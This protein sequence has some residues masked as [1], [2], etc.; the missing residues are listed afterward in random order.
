MGL[1][2]SPISEMF[3]DECRLSKE[4]LLGKEGQGS[5]I[6]NETMAWERTC[7]FACHI[8]AIERTLEE[9][10]KYAKA[11][12][13]FGHPIGKYQ[14]IAHKIADIKVNL[15]LG[16]LILY[17]AG[18]MKSKNMN[19]MLESAIA[20]L[21]VSESLKS[22]TVDAVQIHGSY[23]YMAEMGIERELRDSIAATIYSGTSEIQK[24]IISA[25]LGL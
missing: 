17:K 1:N 20:K 12:K 16:R 7:L 11:R 15:E 4:H 13:Q 25:V 10:I 24:N 3:F 14:S 21:F 5:V 9:C 2:T 18:W 8:G 19:I 6:F 23:G 22:A